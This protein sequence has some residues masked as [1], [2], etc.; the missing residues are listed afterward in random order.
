MIPVFQSSTTLM[1]PLSFISFPSVGKSIASCAC[2][3]T[4]FLESRKLKHLTPFT[5]ERD[6]MAAARLA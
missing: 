6:F 3:A 4:E 1:R 2:A 5:L